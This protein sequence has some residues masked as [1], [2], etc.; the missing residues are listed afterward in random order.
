MRNTVHL[1][2]KKIVTK[3]NNKKCGGKKKNVMS[4]NV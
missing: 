3:K 4:K 2:G 1:N